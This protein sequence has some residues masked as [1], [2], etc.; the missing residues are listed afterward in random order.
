M[1]IA[2]FCYFSLQNSD[3]NKCRILLTFLKN[4]VF[5]CFSDHNSKQNYNQF[6]AEKNADKHRILQECEWNSAHIVI[7]ILTRKAAEVSHNHIA[8]K[9]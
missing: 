1:I 7:R 6:T 2:D 9:L 8:S 4:L 3:Y 5:I